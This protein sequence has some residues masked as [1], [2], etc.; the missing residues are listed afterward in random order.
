MVPSRYIDVLEMYNH[1]NDYRKTHSPIMFQELLYSVALDHAV[2]TGWFM[3]E[4]KR[5][6]ALYIKPIKVHEVY[7]I[8]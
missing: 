1:H 5:Y 2:M 8:V 4:D 7:N 3:V 6:K